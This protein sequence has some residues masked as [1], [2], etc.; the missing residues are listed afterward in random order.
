VYTQFKGCLP[1]I[2]HGSRVLKTGLLLQH[3]ISISTSVME[4]FI[5]NI[6]QVC[7]LYAYIAL[8]NWTSRQMH[9]FLRAL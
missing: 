3:G 8:I 4:S 9:N 7:S 6:L 1:A 5:H 2:G